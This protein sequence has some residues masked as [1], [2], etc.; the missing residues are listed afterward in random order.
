[1]YFGPSVGGYH[2][3][4]EHRNLD[5]SVTIHRVRPLSE[6]SHFDDAQHQH[7][8]A[9][10]IKVIVA[11]AVLSTKLSAKDVHL[12][13]VGAHGVAVS[14]LDQCTTG[15]QSSPSVVRYIHRFVILSVQYAIV[16]RTSHPI[17][18]ESM[19]DW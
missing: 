5:W 11:L 18:R 3:H 13:L 16:A 12:V 10:L 7:T 6:P 2:Q 4:S 17:D 19:K 9:E 15:L 14:T 1:M 8:E